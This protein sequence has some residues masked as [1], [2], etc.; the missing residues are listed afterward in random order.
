MSQKITNV[1]ARC[2]RP[3]EA[4]KSECPRF[5]ETLPS[6]LQEESRGG[7]RGEFSKLHKA[8]SLPLELLIKAHCECTYAKT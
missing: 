3:F 6:I 7:K 2:F 5:D 4:L 8:F 1:E